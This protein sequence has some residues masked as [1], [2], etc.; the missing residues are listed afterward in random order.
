MCTATDVT[1]LKTQTDSPGAPMPVGSY[2]RNLECTMTVRDVMTWN[3]SVVTPRT[4]LE[5]ALHLFKTIG[6][7]ILVVYDGRLYQGLLTRRAVLMAKDN[8]SS[9]AKQ[10]TAS[11]IMETT[12]QPASPHDLL[13]NI[14]E[15]MR[16]A[17]HTYLPVLDEKGR[18][19]GML[20]MTAIKAQFPRS[21]KQYQPS[22]ENLRGTHNSPAE[23]NGR[24]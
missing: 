21:T 19:A 1:R 15:H 20:T 7:E 6:S 11:D 9:S 5:E 2:P 12:F 24:T 22:S 18:L 10:W 17:G 16:T 23:C 3:V 8:C 4:T 14:Y 13:W